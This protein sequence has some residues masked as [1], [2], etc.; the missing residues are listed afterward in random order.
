MGFIRELNMVQLTSGMMW[1][2]DVKVIQLGNHLKGNA[3]NY[4]Q[5]N[6]ESWMQECSM[7]EHV[8][9]RIFEAYRVILPPKQARIR[10]EARTAPGRNW[11][12]HLYHPIGSKSGLFAE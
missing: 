6:V 9:I 5:R 3:L 8:M 12:E 10:F 7:L 4:Y 11:L 1:P 2:E